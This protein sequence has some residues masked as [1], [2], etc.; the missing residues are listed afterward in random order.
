M[1]IWFGIWKIG[2][3]PKKKVEKSEQTPVLLV[4][5]FKNMNLVTETS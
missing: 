2:T 1:I 3:K 4:C 5:K